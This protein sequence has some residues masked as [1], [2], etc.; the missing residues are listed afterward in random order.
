MLLFCFLQRLA[1]NR[2]GSVGVEVL[3]RILITNTQL[4]LIDL[5]GNDLT[6]VD[7]ASLASALAVSLLVGVIDVNSF[8]IISIMLVASKVTTI[9]SVCVIFG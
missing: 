2:V 6:D 9:L 1:D 7:V 8:S 3:S 4:Q 5:T